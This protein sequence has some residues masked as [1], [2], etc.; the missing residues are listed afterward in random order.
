MWRW[1]FQGGTA[2]SKNK[3]SYLVCESQAEL[4]HNGRTSPN[5]LKTWYLG[6]QLHADRFK[7]INNCAR[8]VLETYGYL[9]TVKLNKGKKK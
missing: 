6:I 4:S 3:F 2:V 5:I 7:D 8:Q 9:D 1:S